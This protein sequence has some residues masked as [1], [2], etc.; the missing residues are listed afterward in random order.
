MEGAPRLLFQRRGFSGEIKPMKKHVSLPNLI[1]LLLL[2]FLATGCF[3]TRDEIAREKEDAEM[4]STLQQNVVDNGQGLEK[5]QS[6]IGRLQGR[7]EELE[8]NHKKELSGLTS[9][10]GSKTETNAKTLDEMRAKLNSLQ[11]G[12]TA[13]F[14]EIKKLKED[15]LQLAKQLGEHP[16]K[17]AAPVATG[18]KKGGSSYEAAVSSFKAKDYGAA[19]SAFR[20]FLEANP[21][22]KHALDARFYL[23]ESLYKSKDYTQAIVEFGTIHEK[24]PTSAF[25][26]RATLRIAQSFR[27]MGKDKDARAF[28]QILVDTSPNS[29]EAKKAKA[30]LK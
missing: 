26:R 14:E 9:S 23:G 29:E 10:L 13:L 19:I 17:S 11:E 30:M 4:R 8:H 12:Q 2:P 20:G 27:A 1:V 18:K 24:T 22:S 25:G 21:K 7:M 15:N 28:A 6:E 5:L 3:K 16:Q